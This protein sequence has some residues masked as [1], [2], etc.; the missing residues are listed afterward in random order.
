MHFVIGW[1]AHG[2]AAAADRIEAEF[3]GVIAPYK[4]VRTLDNVFIVQVEGQ[5]E[6]DTILR[7]ISRVG[8]DQPVSVLMSPL[9]DGGRYNG[10][11]LED[12]WE[13]INA[14]TDGVAADG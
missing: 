4:S 2:P 11:L 1:Q 9:M 6:W 3:E 12:L 7:G 10:L 5:E 13:E 14:I 8:R